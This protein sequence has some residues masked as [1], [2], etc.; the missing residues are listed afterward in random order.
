MGLDRHELGVVHFTWSR[1]VAYNM[2]RKF[3]NKWLDALL[4]LDFLVLNLKI[5]LKLYQLAN[6]RLLL[7]S[8][9]L[10]MG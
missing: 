3:Y 6:I 2:I 4:P 5:W 1:N 7:W 9:I 8:L 10:V